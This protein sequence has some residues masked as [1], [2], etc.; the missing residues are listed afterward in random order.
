LARA[1]NNF[2]D[3]E[4]LGQGG[5][6]AVY[7]GILRES[8]SYIAVKRVSKG[9]KQGI[10]EYASEV[11]IISRLRHRNLV[12]LINWCHERKGELLLVYD[13]M[14]NGSLDSH[15][16]KEERL[17]IWAVRYKLLKAWP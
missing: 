14:P 12:Q 9:S 4:K 15:L 5:F 1:T 2:N 6:G 16:F 7:K 17:M 13:F 11:K 3:E 8:N 10:K